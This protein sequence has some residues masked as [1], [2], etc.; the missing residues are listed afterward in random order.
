LHTKPAIA[1]SRDTTICKNSQARLS[2]T[3]GVG[4]TWSPS[5]TLNNH[6]ISN[7]VASPLT[8]T[9]YYV[10]VK[11][12]NTCEYLDSVAVSIRP[13][14]VFAVN[15]PAPICRFDSTQLIA[16]GG[17]IYSWQPVL[18]IANTTISN[19]KVSPA[20]TTDYTVT[21]T[22][23]TCN[24]SKTLS[25]R[26][27]VMPLPVLNAAKSNDIDCRNDR[28]QLNASGA[29]QYLWSP[30]VTLNNP[31]ISNPV[32]SP[33]SNTR[34]IVT[35][36]TINGCSANDTID[37][38]VYPKPV[39][40][41][42]NDTTI[43]KNAGAQLLVSGGSSYSW[44]PVA[45]LNDHRVSNPV[46]SP[47][48]DTRYYVSITDDIACVYLDSVD[49][50]VRPDPAF[51]ITGPAKICKGDT[52]QLNASGGDTYLWNS[53]EELSSQVIP[54]P[55]AFPAATKDYTVTISESFCNQSATL[56]TRVTVL[57]APVVN[58]S[59][60]NDIDCSNDRSQL[61]AS[62]ASQYTWSPS[63]SLNNPS[64][65]NPIAA[66]VV[67]TE[68]VVKGTDADGCTGFDT[69]IV[70]AETSNKSGYLMPNAFTPDNDGL[71]DCF[72]VRYWGVVSQFE[73]SIYN[74]WGER[75][76][77][78][79]NPE[80]CWDGTYKG[81]EQDGGVYVY[82]IKATTTCQPEVFRKGTFVLIR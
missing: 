68:Y 12:V 33:A 40:V 75:I 58:A 79:R 30:A 16:T 35:G 37:V 74:R 14:A 31:R 10:V 66:P 11:D 38:I 70:K 53:P 21:I 62:G 26:L 5:P 47:T 72:R 55:F 45:T 9:K 69:I 57:S 52:L 49:V 20:S 60:S 32:A 43:C 41:V 27:I 34:Y 15:T 7:P 76:F 6:L 25:T 67:T 22:E 28:S 18:G 44:S 23:L 48:A 46:A 24:Q 54:D 3:G 78:T 59:K 29:D 64:L 50:S 65:P 80:H 42:S 13:D 1:V 4:Y 81:I 51:S 71:N 36:T 8:N 77:F 61:L 82:M 19:P 2:A 73:F 17:D 56:S 63:G 39:I